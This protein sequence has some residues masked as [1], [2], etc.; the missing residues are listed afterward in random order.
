M[1]EV[2][3]PVSVLAIMLMFVDQIRR[4]VAHAILNSTIRKA[5]EKDPA[6]VPLLVNKLE[7]R[8]R[9]SDGLIG[10]ILLLGGLALGVAGLFE[11]ADDR[12]ATFQVASIA[13][14]IGTGVLI[15]GWFV[16]RASPLK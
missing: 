2:V 8:R 6:S 13:A 4:L 7:L 5:M 9:A 14:V 11:T 16:D 1:L 10:V 3:L 12:L 15:Y